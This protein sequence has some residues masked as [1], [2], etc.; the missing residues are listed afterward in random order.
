MNDTTLSRIPFQVSDEL[1]IASMAGWMRFVGVIKVVSGLVTLFVLLVG[2]IYI[3]TALGLEKP[4][5]EGIASPSIT[6]SVNGTTHQVPLEKVRRVVSEQRV[7][8]VALGAFGLILGGAGVAL[9]FMLFQA[10]DAFDKVARTDAADQDFITAGIAQLN[11]YFKVSILL[12]VAAGVV[13]ITAG[14]ALVAE[15]VS[16]P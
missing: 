4:T 13:A 12:G 14:L 7:T 9:G 11:L 2:I 16:A 8:F 5:R 1:M 6:I 3:G 15:G 10:A